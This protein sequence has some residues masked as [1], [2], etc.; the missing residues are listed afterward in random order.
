MLA[1]ATRSG[2]ATLETRLDRL[3]GTGWTLK[4][5]LITPPPVDEEAW[6]RATQATHGTPDIPEARRARN[7]ATTGEYARAVVALAK[8]LQLP[9]VDLHSAMMA[10]PDWKGLL[11]DGLHFND[12]GQVFVYGAVSEVI[13]IAAPHLKPGPSQRSRRS[14]PSSPRCWWGC[15]CVG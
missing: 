2:P 15:L 3:R 5:V 8:S 14:D 10:Q 12:K 1:S 7:N 4:V 13:D 11:S 9:V 6:F